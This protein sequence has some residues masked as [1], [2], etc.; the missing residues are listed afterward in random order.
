MTLIREKRLTTEIPNYAGTRFLRE[1][2]AWSPKS[3]GP[4]AFKDADT[5][6]NSMMI[7]IWGGLTPGRPRGTVRVEEQD[8]TR[9]ASQLRV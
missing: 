3:I 5:K 7:E 1:R 8:N 9:E 4:S 2:A 6:V